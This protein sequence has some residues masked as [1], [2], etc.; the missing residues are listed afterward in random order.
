MFIVI[1]VKLKQKLSD[2]T[3]WSLGT[4][5]SVQLHGCSAEYSPHHPL[6]SEVNCIYST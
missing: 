4:S 2:F 5:P 6:L 1:P 3:V